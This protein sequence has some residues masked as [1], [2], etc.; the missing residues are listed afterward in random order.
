MVVTTSYQSLITVMADAFVRHCFLP[1]SH[2]QSVKRN[3]RRSDGQRPDVL[4]TNTTNSANKKIGF[5]SPCTDKIQTTH[6]NNKNN[7]TNVIGAALS[8]GKGRKEVW[9]LELNCY[10]TIG[11]T[12]LLKKQ[13]RLVSATAPPEKQK[14]IKNVRSR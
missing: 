6:I 11:Q 3:T 7:K 4:V 13:R 2:G 1:S 12:R 8:S 14:I 5:G 10:T 9:L